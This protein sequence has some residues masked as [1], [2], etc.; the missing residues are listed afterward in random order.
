MCEDCKRSSSRPSPD[1]RSSV[2][3]QLRKQLFHVD[4]PCLWSNWLSTCVRWL[5]RGSR[6]QMTR[7]LTN[8]WAARWEKDHIVRPVI[9]VEQAETA[10]QTLV[11]PFQSLE[12]EEED[13]MK[14]HIQVVRLPVHYYAGLLFIFR[15]FCVERKWEAT[16]G[17]PWHSNHAQFIRSGL[18]CDD[19]YFRFHVSFF[20]L[21]L[22]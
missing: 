9:C 19:Q 13:N 3:H 10:S 15:M 20:F 8:M 4:P 6:K 1:L 18:R 7:R 11:R 21:I 22:Q 12:H 5:F 16:T 2:T 17:R 14:R